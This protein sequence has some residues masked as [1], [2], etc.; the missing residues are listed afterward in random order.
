MS[1]CV[2]IQVQCHPGK[3]YQVANDI[4][5]REIHSSLYSTS[6]EFDLFI[7]LYVPDGE[8]VGKFINDK[9]LDIDGIQRTLTTLTFNAF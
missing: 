5:D 9:I 2:F 6:G 8:D 1:Q 3:A 7:L 4:A